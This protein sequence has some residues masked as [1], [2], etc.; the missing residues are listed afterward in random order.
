[1]LWYQRWHTCMTN[2]K[3]LLGIRKVNQ[4]MGKKV[5]LS[6]KLGLHNCR[7][8]HFL[9]CIMQH[10]VFR[11]YYGLLGISEF[12][13]KLAWGHS[14][15]WVVKSSSGK[16]AV[17]T[18]H[19]VW[20]KCR[21]QEFTF[22]LQRMTWKHRTP[23]TLVLKPLATQLNRMKHW[24]TVYSERAMKHGLRKWMSNWCN[25][26]PKLP[27]SGQKS[28]VMIC[29]ERERAIIF[30]SGGKKRGRHQ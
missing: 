8:P 9:H 25:E 7:K 30:I 2:N 20:A 6:N 22:Q 27:E 18:T 3:T 23:A 19:K 29:T 11:L 24:P 14:E 26:G 13:P 12:I 17:L 1:M 15:H 10:W 28:C 5:L 21:K 4:W 16:A